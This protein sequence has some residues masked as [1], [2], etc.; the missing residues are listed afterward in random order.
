MDTAVVRVGLLV[1]AGDAEAVVQKQEGGDR[2]SLHEAAWVPAMEKSH[3][4]SGCVQRGALLIA[5]PKKTNSVRLK[6]RLQ[7]KKK[8]T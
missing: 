4:L 5:C 3:E 1:V 8:K 7:V 6:H 2:S